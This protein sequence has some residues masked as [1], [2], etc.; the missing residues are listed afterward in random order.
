MIIIDYFKN[1]SDKIPEEFLKTAII[2]FICLKQ[3]IGDY[4]PQI[5]YEVRK[6]IEEANY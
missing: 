2:K 3:K 5:L 6:I 4:M 1:Q